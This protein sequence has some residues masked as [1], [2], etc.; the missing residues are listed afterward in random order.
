MIE[1]DGV[2]AVEAGKIVFVGSVVAV[3]A[4]HVERAV[5]DWRRPQLTEKLGGDAEV[6]FAVFVSGNG[7]KEVARIGES[8]CTDGS[9][10]RQ[11]KRKTVVFADVAARLSFDIRTTRNLTPRGMTLISPGATSR[12]PSSVWRRRA[13]S[14]GTRRSSPSA[15]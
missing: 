15:V 1:G 3:P 9:E 10:F 8:V 14:C 2:D 6:A 7:G 13:P 11:A 5:I 4:D 12:M